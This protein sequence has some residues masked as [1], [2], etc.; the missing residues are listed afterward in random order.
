MGGTAKAME[1][2]FWCGRVP[3]DS[4]RAYALL[5]RDA[6]SVFPVRFES[7]VPLTTGAVSGSIPG[8]LC[9]ES[10]FKTVRNVQ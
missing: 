8:F 2:G 9:L 3:P 10:D 4:A 5:G 7:A 1:V 6:G